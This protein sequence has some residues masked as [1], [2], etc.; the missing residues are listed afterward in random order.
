[1][2]KY[3][4]SNDLFEFIRISGSRAIFRLGSNGI[5]SIHMEDHKQ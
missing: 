1:M 5:G 2:I 3:E 4:G